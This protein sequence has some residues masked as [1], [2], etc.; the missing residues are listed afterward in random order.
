MLPFGVVL[1]YG[2]SLAVYFM[3]AV[4][5]VWREH[6]NTRAIIVLNVLL[7]WTVLGW[8]FALVWA[9]TQVYRHDRSHGDLPPAWSA[10]YDKAQWSSRGRGERTPSRW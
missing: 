8:V 2:F 1:L 7:G 3:P 5:A 10:E 6:H 4:V 9:C